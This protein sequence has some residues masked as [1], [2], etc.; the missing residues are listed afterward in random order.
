MLTP[1]SLRAGRRKM[2]A[3]ALL[4]LCFVAATTARNV[5]DALDEGEPVSL[6]ACFRLLLK[7]HSILRI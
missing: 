6:P 4:L 2:K 5:P 1:P 3:I 7:K